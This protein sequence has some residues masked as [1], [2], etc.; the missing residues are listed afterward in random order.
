M[1][2]YMSWGHAFGLGHTNADDLWACE[3]VMCPYGSHSTSFKGDFPKGLKTSALDKAALKR[4]YGVGNY[5]N[6]WMGTQ[7][8]GPDVY[9]EIFHA[10]AKKGKI[11]LFWG[12]DYQSLNPGEPNEGL[13]A[14]FYHYSIYY[15]PR[16]EAGSTKIFEAT[17]RMDNNWRALTHGSELHPCIASG[18]TGVNLTFD[19]ESENLEVVVGEGDLSGGWQIA[20][21]QLDIV[22]SYASSLFPRFHFWGAVSGEDKEIQV[23]GWDH[24]NTADKTYKDL[25]DF[26]ETEPCYINNS[27]LNID[28][29]V[30]ANFSRR[31][32]DMFDLAYS[33]NELE[34]R[35]YPYGWYPKS[36]WNKTTGDQ[37]R[38]GHTWSTEGTESTPI[39]LEGEN[40][41]RQDDYSNLDSIYSISDTIYIT[42][43]QFKIVV[44]HSSHD[45]ISVGFSS[46]SMI[47]SNDGI[48]PDEYALFTGVGSTGLYNKYLSVFGVPV[49][50]TNKT[51]DS[52][53]AQAASVLAQYI[54]NDQD[55]IEDNQDLV[56]SIIDSKSVLLITENEAE[57]TN[58]GSLFNSVWENG[59]YNARVIYT[60]GS[61]AEAEGVEQIFHFVSSGGYSNLDTGV[62][63][64]KSGSVI[65]EL[66]DLARS[67][68]F[69]SVPQD[70]TYGGGPANGRYPSGA[71]FHSADSTCG[72]SCQ[73]NQYIWWGVST[74]MG[75]NEARCSNVSGEWGHQDYPS[76]LCSKTGLYVRDLNLYDLLTAS[77]YRFPTV[78]PSGEYRGP[79]NHT[80]VLNK[81]PDGEKMSV[82]LNV[83]GRDGSGVFEYLTGVQGPDVAI[84][85]LLL[86]SFYNI[87]GGSGL[88][89][90]GQGSYSNQQMY[91]M[92]QHL[93]ARP[94]TKSPCE[95]E[96]SYVSGII[97]T[98]QPSPFYTQ[99]NMSSGILQKLK[100][101]FS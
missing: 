64:L 91:L 60:T 72:Y 61:F 66:T 90:G 20:N 94:I 93:N 62:F 56:K 49:L 53:F 74:L 65:A 73:V 35:G 40:N 68:H 47:N 43:D 32:V 19:G 31:S 34:N 23:S 86:E 89:T 24:S 67:G 51:S 57:Y 59:G 77:G 37:G 10:G 30:L 44:D 78:S 6:R 9:S 12:G 71:W 7:K 55:G 52:S 54:D 99:E 29:G 36:W 38:V 82:A 39:F 101:F 63:G 69:E 80:R 96:I 70:N 48:F 81:F 87:S 13:Y 11:N 5:D 27:D 25:Y 97:H 16:N 85:G 45:I 95:R 50:A 41:G 46:G 28:N 14:D 79:S 33:Y 3:S 17:G 15:P 92:S 22:E 98:G 83:I 2:R 100:D 18:F 58:T 84:S 76:Q 21:S 1:P 42:G 26:D 75:F 88:A 8:E 4:L